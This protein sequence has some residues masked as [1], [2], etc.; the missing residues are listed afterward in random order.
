[1]PKVLVVDESHEVRARLEE[2]LERGRLERGR[3][4]VLAATSGAQALE[5][6]ERDRPDLVVCDVYMPDMD[7]Y[8]V[9]NFVRA[10]PELGATPVLLMADIVDRTA[11]A[12]GA[13]AGSDD[14][15]RKPCSPHEL[16]D[17]IESLLP[18]T[19]GEPTDVDPGLDSPADPQVL[20]RTVAELPGVSFAVL[21]DLEG[22]VLDCAGRMALEAEMVAALVSSLGEWS[23]AIGCDLGHGALQSMICEYDGGVVLFMGVD[24]TSRLAVVLRDPSALEAVRRCVRQV[25]PA[26]L[27]A[28]RGAS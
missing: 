17:R 1:M 12:R 10:H 23:E 13:R 5:R 22:F 28:P 8:R 15:V 9:C 21:M 6:I 19:P 26:L 7:G 2:A 16:I 18:R 24:S 3:V 27:E 14:V 11:L 20:L 25:A 4:E